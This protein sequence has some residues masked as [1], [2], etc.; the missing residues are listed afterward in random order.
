MN[1]I[2]NRRHAVITEC[3]GKYMVQMYLTFPDEPDYKE[4][5]DAFLAPSKPAAIRRAEGWVEA[6]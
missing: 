2:K 1:L 4:L 3:A 6:G 5:I